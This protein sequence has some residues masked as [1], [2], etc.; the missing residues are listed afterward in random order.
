MVEHQGYFF[1]DLAEGMSASFEKRITDE[2]IVK[3]A[4]VT[5]DTN[6][7]HLDDEFA[8]ESIFE[9]RIAHGMLTASLFSAI[10]GTRMPGPGCIYMNQSI[11]FRAPVRPGELALATVTV[12]RIDS[13]KQRVEF[14]CS[15]VVGNTVV[16]DGEA[17]VKVPSRA[18]G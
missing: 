16:A 11:R 13:A 9:G 4:E 18:R 3:F 5:G 15:C 7:L 14:D 8:R 12:K 1:E 6:P 2:D 10:L 17:M